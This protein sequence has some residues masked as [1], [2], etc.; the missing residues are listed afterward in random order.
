MKRPNL[1]YWR[2]QVIKVCEDYN[3]KTT[4]ILTGHYNILEKKE[5]IKVMYCKINS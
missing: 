4:D 1:W 2:M 5:T 3:L